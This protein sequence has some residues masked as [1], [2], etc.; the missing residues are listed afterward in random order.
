MTPPGRG[1]RLALGVLR[2]NST[3]RVDDAGETLAG[4]LVVRVVCAPAGVVLVGSVFV[5]S[6]P[7]VPGAVPAGAIGNVLTWPGATSDCSVTVNAL[8]PG[9][10]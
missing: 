4:V 10:A 9:P 2:T 3:P 8:P 1:R 5:S 6:V 7:A